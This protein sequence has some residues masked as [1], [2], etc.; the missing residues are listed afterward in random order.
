MVA[1]RKK[2]AFFLG[3]STLMFFVSFFVFFVFILFFIFTPSYA[4]DAGVASVAGGQ[5]YFDTDAQAIVDSGEQGE[6]VVQEEGADPLMAGVAQDSLLSPQDIPSLFFTYWQHEAIMEAKN[7]RGAVRPPTQAELDAMSRENM[8]KPPPEERELRLG[9]I[10][11]VNNKEWT[12]WLNGER[13][14]PDAVPKEVLDLQVFKE[15]IEVKWLDEYTN[16]VF[17]IRLRTH[18]RFNMD[19][20]IFLPG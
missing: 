8:P 12:V 20:R 4:Q 10:V 17:P 6:G 3:Q 9:G 13:V 15:Y 19:M 11:Y 5:E 14:T 16:R 7:S 18:Q 2:Q 1:S